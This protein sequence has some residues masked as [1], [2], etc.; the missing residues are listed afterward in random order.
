VQFERGFDEHRFLIALYVGGM[1]AECR[2]DV[3]WRLGVL[4]CGSGH[5]PSSHGG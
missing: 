5:I 3:G 2:L 1:S 4:A